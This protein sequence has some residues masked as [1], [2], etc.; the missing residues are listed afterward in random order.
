[1]SG[2]RGHGRIGGVFFLEA[3]RSAEKSGGFGF[4]S[5]FGDV[6]LNFPGAV[7][8]PSFFGILLL[9]D[10]IGDCICYVGK[11]LILD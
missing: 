2:Q 11:H 9:G 6:I 10:L 5:K 3:V 8:M 1:L 7:L 4:G